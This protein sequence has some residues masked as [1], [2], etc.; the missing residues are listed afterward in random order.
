MLVTD[1][2]SYYQFSNRILFMYL[3]EDLDSDMTLFV[4]ADWVLSFI[5]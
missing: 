4:K 1:H 2:T 3:P 5:Q